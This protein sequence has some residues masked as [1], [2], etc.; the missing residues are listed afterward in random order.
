M[1]DVAQGWLIEVLLPAAYNDGTAIPDEVLADIR[2]A[3]VDRFGGLTAFTR[4]PAEGGWTD[5]DSQHHDDIVVL[6]VMADD[7]DRQWWGAW[8]K[9]AEGVLRQEE[10]VVRAR[11]IERL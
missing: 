3:L 9:R 6:E 8:R 4:S 2:R 11:Q 5:G 10:I 1:I 7:L